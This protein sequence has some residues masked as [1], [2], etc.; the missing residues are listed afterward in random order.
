[1][2]L[3]AN[4]VAVITGGTRGLGLAIARA[5]AAEG[6]AVVVGSRSQ[7][8][9]LD[10]VHALQAVG[11]EAA[12]MALDVADLAQVQALA[13]L[14]LTTY[15][16]IDTWV[17]AAGIAGSYGPTLDADPQEY[18]RVIQTNIVGTYNGSRTALAIMQPR[19]CGK[20]INLL[21][22][23]YNSPT[24]WQSAYGAS[25][26]WVRMFTLA[27]ASETR[28][29][30]VGVFAFQPGMVLTD[31]L[32]DIRVIEGSEQRLKVFPVVVRILAQPPEVPARKAAWIASSAT[33]GKT[34]L[35]VKAS[36]V[37]MQLSGALRE[38][39]RV[40]RHKP[41]PDMGIRVKVVPPFGG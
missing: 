23:G 41:A 3:L 37:G 13:A 17:N 20:L 24:P 34:G 26:S 36:T 11:A 29:S 38:L 40:I 4:R 31:L 5:M 22:M 27:L 19:G 7:Q 15:G 39:W 32:T 33:D 2:Q 28:G 21:G 25:K 8:A 6:A 9:V 14:A 18:N 10:A 16:Q 12:G 35:I 30:G 1:M